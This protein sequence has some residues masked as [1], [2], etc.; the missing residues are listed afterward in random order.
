MKKFFSIFMATALMLSF[1]ACDKK[2]KSSDDPTTPPETPTETGINITISSESGNVKYNDQCSSQGWW[3]IQ[4]ENDKYYIT[5]SN[6]DPV[7]A[8]PGIYTAA[9]L[10]PEYSFIEVLE[11]EEQIDFTAGKITLTQT[12]EK[13]TI[14]GALTGSDKK[15]YN[16]NL[17]YTFPVKPDVKETVQVNI[18]EGSADGSYVSSYGLWVLYGTTTGQASG[19]YVEMYFNANE[20]GQLTTELANAY[21]YL[22]YEDED[23]VEL[24]SAELVGLQQ[25]AD[26]YIFK[27]ELLAL[28]GTLYQVTFN[29]PISGEG[30]D[31]A[32]PAKAPAKKVFKVKKSDRK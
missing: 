20:A 29:L 6:L 14:V 3:Q 10:D 9:K 19:T 13:V 31:E 4:A 1:A 25:T 2:D 15:E 17:S 26:A 5:L 22:D 16:I 18:P 30:G 28:D 32:A 23:P 7:D 11:T 8:A 12:A 24:Y 21:L 27:L